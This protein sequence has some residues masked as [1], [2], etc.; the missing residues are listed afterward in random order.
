MMLV[1]ASNI[2]CSERQFSLM[3]HIKNPKRNRTG[4]DNMNAII[5][6][7]QN[8]KYVNIKDITKRWITGEWK[9]RA[10]KRG[11]PSKTMSSS[12]SSSLSH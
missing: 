4:D 1:I 10:K 11:P 5:H 8:K 9:Q 12:S 7:N 2:A 6:L 3:K